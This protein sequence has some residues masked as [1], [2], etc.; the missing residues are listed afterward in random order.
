MYTD[1]GHQS[2]SF[3]TII[4]PTNVSNVG[5]ALVAMRWARKS[6]KAIST[7][8]STRTVRQA[9]QLP[10]AIVET[11]SLAL[12]YVSILQY[13]PVAHKFTSRIG[14]TTALRDRVARVVLMDLVPKHLLLRLHNV[15][16]SFERRLLLYHQAM[17]LSRFRVR[18]AKRHSNLSLWK[19][20]RIG[21]GETRLREMIGYA[22]RT[23]AV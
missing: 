15:T 18:S 8:T 20:T 11:G 2:P 5:F 10:A 6:L 17:R 22:G 14:Y 16:L 9:R 3:C 1:N 21:Y 7:C 12:R 13:N 19:M 4:C 23:A